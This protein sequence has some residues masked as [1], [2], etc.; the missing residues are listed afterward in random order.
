MQ[1]RR[2][3]GN[4]RQ[5]HDTFRE[6]IINR[7]EPAIKAVAWSTLPPPRAGPI[8]CRL[9]LALAL[10]GAPFGLGITAPAGDILAMLAYLLDGLKAKW[11]LVPGQLIWW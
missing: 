3:I 8:H 9:N 1:V 6:L 5:S 11:Q 4:C 2:L 7:R 10:L